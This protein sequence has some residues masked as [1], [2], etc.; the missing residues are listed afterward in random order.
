[1]DGRKLAVASQLPTAAP[2]AYGTTA[3]PL[4]IGSVVSEADT[5]ASGCTAEQPADQ[6][7]C[8]REHCGDGAHQ[9]YSLSRGA[10]PAATA[11]AASTP[12][13]A[14]PAGSRFSAV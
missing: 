12:M 4:G 13:A 6:I 5:S 1:M 10:I 9:W 3:A 8:E 7:D 11:S 14:A 2:K